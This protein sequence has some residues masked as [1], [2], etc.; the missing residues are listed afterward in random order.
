V[1]ARPQLRTVSAPASAPAHLRCLQVGLA[2]GA[3]T[4]LHVAEHD[5]AR[6]EV[7]VVRFAHPTPLAAWCAAEGV[8]EAIVGG[9]FVRPGGTPLGE[10]RTR[11]IVRPSVAFDPPWGGIRACVHSVG[12]TLEIARRPDLHGEPRG[13]LLQ[14]GP[15]LVADGRA[16]TAGD[17][18]GFSAGAS[19][20]DSDITAGRYPR[21][22]LAL[23]RRGRLLAVAADGR[24]D[25]DAGLTMDELAEALVALGAVRAINLDGGGSTSLVCGGELRNVPREEHGI[26][27]VGGRPVATAIAFTP[28]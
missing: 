13:D 21:A 8:D 1:P 16:C 2:D 18:E 20:F 17:P 11:G 10:L 9:F 4:S 3:R 6:T 25:G 28:R 19:Q 5:L 24:A 14:A 26:E 23:T 15:L 7:R 22:A 12:G 27:L